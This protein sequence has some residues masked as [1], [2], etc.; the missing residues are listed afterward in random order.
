[1]LV[2]G[3]SAFGFWVVGRAKPTTVA[4]LDPKGG[5]AL[6]FWAVGRAKSKTAPHLQ[7]KIELALG[8]GENDIAKP[9]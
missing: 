6:A 2:F 1:M 9:P 7:P 3:T 4:H 8:S 5:L